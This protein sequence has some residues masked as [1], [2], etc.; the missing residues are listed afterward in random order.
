MLAETL[1][2]S[3][4]TGSCMVAEKAKGNDGSQEFESLGTSS[5]D[6]NRQRVRRMP[7]RYTDN[8]AM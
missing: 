7:A 5:E 8:I 4:A 1:L 2:P 3:C 6:W